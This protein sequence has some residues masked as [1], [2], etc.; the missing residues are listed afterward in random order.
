MHCSGVLNDDAEH[1]VNN[2]ASIRRLSEIA[3]SY[4][5]AGSQVRR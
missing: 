1:S 3:V 4:A 5:K 2:E